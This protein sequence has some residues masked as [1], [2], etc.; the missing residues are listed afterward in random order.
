MT[1]SMTRFA[2][3]TLVLAAIAATATPSLAETS[4]PQRA[5]SQQIV[6]I[7]AT[8]AATR[9]AYQREF[10]VQPVFV[11]ARE[12]LNARSNGETWSTPRC[13]TAR[14]YARLNQLA[15]TRAGL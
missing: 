9:R 14:E 6:M 7:C 1:R 3:P 2:S 4:K 11:S 5:E 12:T 10:G 15:E 13:M 8:D